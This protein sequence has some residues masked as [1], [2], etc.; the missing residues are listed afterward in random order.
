MKK[1]SSFPADNS[2]VVKT[3]GVGGGNAGTLCSVLDSSGDLRLFPNTELTDFRNSG[4]ELDHSTCSVPLSIKWSKYLLAIYQSCHCTL[5][6]SIHSI[7]L[8]NWH[9]HGK[10]MIK[11][12][13]HMRDFLYEVNFIDSF[14]CLWSE[15]FS[16]SLKWVWLRLSRQLPLSEDWTERLTLQCSSLGML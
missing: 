16:H 15:V 8:S 6:F 3:K 4:T 12:G 2:L 14:L 10:T 9:I 11:T 13:T 1:K 5:K 7:S